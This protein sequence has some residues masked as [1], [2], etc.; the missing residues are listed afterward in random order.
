MNSKQEIEDIKFIYKYAGYNR[1]N[2][3]IKYIKEKDVDFAKSVGLYQ[4]MEKN[5]IF[6]ISKYCLFPLLL[7]ECV[8]H[9]DI[10]RLSEMCLLAHYAGLWTMIQDE[11]FDSSIDRHNYRVVM[12]APLIFR[13]RDII[14]DISS[15]ADRV[16]HIRKFE[17][18]MLRVIQG[19]RTE[20]EL[21]QRTNAS[22]I[23]LLKYCQDKYALVFFLMEFLMDLYD[24]KCSYKGEILE[25]FKGYSILR[26]CVDELQDIDEDKNEENMNIC[27]FLGNN[28]VTELA[29]ENYENSLNIAREYGEFGLENLINLTKNTE[30]LTNA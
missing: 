9:F 23:E 15:P 22:E 29:L 19:F 25:A 17:R 21:N 16:T 7:K 11:L 20:M 26:Q 3:I 2:S 24:S 30:V 4:G 28:R 1:V 8:N 6:P 10:A 5:E 27:R 18:E 12:L 13:C 14:D